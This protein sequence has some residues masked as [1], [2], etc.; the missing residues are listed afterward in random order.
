MGKRAKNIYYTLG[1]NILTFLMGVVTGFI[2]PKFLGIESYA[3]VK[4]FA[5]YTTYV[6]ISHFG[7]LD[8]IYIKYGAYDY[9]EIPKKKFRGYFKFLVIGQV[10]EFVI[11]C[12]IL[13][14]LNL[15][16]D[17]SFIIFLVLFNMILMNIT[18]FFAFIHQFTKRFKVFSI[19]LVLNKLIYVI[20]SLF[21]LYF[22]YLGYEGFIILQ[23]FINLLVLIIYM[24]INKDLVIGKSSS[25]KNNVKEYFE[26]S[27]S[28]L[29]I[30][31]GNF[32]GI[33]ILGLDRMFVDKYFNIEEFAMYSFAYTLISLFFILLN[34]ITTVIYPYLARM[35]QE[36]RKEIYEKVRISLSAIMAITLSGYFII[37]YIVMIYL[38]KYENSLPI[39]IFLVPTVIYSAQINILIANYYKIL[40]E[41]K[42]YT[43][44]NIIAL[45]LGLISNIIALVVFKSIIAIAVATLISFILW[46]LYSDLYF[47][48]VINVKYKKA[49]Y[50]ELSIIIIF[51]ST[52]I[53]NNWVVGLLIYMA[54]LSLILILFYKKDLIDT[55]KEIVN[56]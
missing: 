31:I 46:L 25:I 6:G 47:S 50:L 8:G 41:T 18:T 21:L 15:D 40:K 49:T 30:M 26:L 24:Y 51:I 10:L 3:Y 56:K 39:L 44:N 29:F 42:A 11:L 20:G 28:G 27:K 14:F 9:D 16:K 48:K 23:T 34:S 7:F 45:I 37:K 55:F 36:N 19:N 1:A 33:F 5:F 2:I 13:K 17:R 38:P 43:K 4:L 12:I 54:I 22:N 52:A 53:I 35:N 32:M